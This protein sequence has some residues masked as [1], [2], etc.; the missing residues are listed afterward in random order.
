MQVYLSEEAIQSITALQCCLAKTN[1]D[2]FLIGHKR[3]NMFIVERILPS[4]TGFFSS[5]EKYFEL[6]NKLDDKILG[7]Y[8]FRTNETKL[9]KILNPF[10]FGKIF[11]SLDPENSDRSEIKPFA[12]E[13]DQKF[14]LQPIDL[15]SAL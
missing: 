9:K 4:S 2:G 13:H 10:G 7:F 8:S 1:T 5:P 15:R 6:K 11:L 3:G 12:I 14:Y